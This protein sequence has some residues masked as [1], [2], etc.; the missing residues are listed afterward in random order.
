M[1]VRRPV[2]QSSV[3]YWRNYEK[4]LGPLLETLA[5]RCGE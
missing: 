2:Y 4:H 5:A 3:G 1:Q